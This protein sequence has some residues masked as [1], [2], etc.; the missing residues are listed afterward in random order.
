MYRISATNFYLFRWELLIFQALGNAQSSVPLQGILTGNSILY[1]D[2]LIITQIKEGSFC[3]GLSFF[4][5]S[6]FKKLAYFFISTKPEN[7]LSLNLPNPSIFFIK[8]NHRTCFPWTYVLPIFS[9][10]W[11][12]L[13]NLLNRLP[14]H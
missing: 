14:A 4:C 1:F 3:N 12:R 11:K 6:H 13:T 10:N 7:I 8:L 9:E 5:N 2:S